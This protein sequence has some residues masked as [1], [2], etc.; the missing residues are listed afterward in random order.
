MMIWN[1]KYETMPREELAQVQIERLQTTL[2][3]VQRSVAFYRA[4]FQAQRVKPEAVS[5]LEDLRRLPFTTREDLRRAY[6]YDMFAVPLKDIVRI[7]CTSG[8]MG[9]PVVVGYT[10]NDVRLWTECVARVLAAGGVSEHDVVQVAFTY[11][12]FS[13]GL[14]L[15]YGAERIGA[16]VVPASTGALD[17]QVMILR[18]FKSTALACTPGYA[19]ALASA[20]RDAGVRRDELS[21]RVGFFGAEPWSE[22][23]RAQLEQRLGITALDNYGLTEILG[24]GVS[25]ECEHKSGLHLN[26]DHFI[27]EVIDPQTG[28]P[29]PAGTP[30]ELVLT[31]ISKEGFPLIRYRTGDIASIDPSPCAC[32]RTLARMSRIGG[33]I[34]DMV[35]VGDVKVLPS[36]V[37]E[38]LASTVG[39]EPHY[40]ILVDR[41]EGI[42]SLEVRVEISEGAQ[43]VDEVRALQELKERIARR[44]LAALTVPVN[45]TLAEPRSIS[46]AGQPGAKQRRVVDRRAL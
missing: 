20:I 28:T 42:D 18:D 1:Q 25:F 19:V 22:S 43:V 30:G 21:L 33:R 3:R 40:Q 35:I 46:A 34:D 38:V 6:P 8:T 4:A 26:E 13:G 37:E 27:A 44:L 23:L 9:H 31:T 7:Q 11:G 5:S 15:H 16:S 12:L 17:R 2:N 24:P 39:V 10:P 36:H 45:V 41:V 32:G 29:L 14:G